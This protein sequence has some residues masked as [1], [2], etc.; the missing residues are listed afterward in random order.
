MKTKRFLRRILVGLATI[1]ACSVT[2]TAMAQV[3]PSPALTGLV[4][5]Q[6]EG[7]MEGVLL[8]VAYSIICSLLTR[9]TWPRRSLA[10]PAVAVS[11]PQAQKGAK[12]LALFRRNG[13]PPCRLSGR[14]SPNYRVRRR[15][16]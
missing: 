1:V 3:A 10:V 7:P 9:I 4:S 12:R 6:E 2:D 13:R 14:K 5:S 16:G 11:P 8:N 15:T